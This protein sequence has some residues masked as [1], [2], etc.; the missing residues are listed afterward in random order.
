MDNNN[1]I[2]LLTGEEIIWQGISSKKKI[3]ISVPFAVFSVMVVLLTVYAFLNTEMGNVK[4]ACVP[5]IAIIIGY[6]AL[7]AYYE[8]K[9]RKTLFIITNMRIIRCDG[10]FS[11]RLSEYRYRQIG[12][13][14]LK[15]DRG[16]KSGSIHFRA[17]DTAATEIVFSD[18]KEV[19][20]VYNL[21]QQ[22]LAKDSENTNSRS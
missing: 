9:R 10:V 7:A 19:V 1:R 8:E 11:Y 14:L 12:D 3:R 6:L 5:I 2:G 18:I 4:Y 15:L 13:I 20:T 17:K 16:N 21:A 22:Q